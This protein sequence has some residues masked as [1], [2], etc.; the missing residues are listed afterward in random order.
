MDSINVYIVDDDKNKKP[1][2]IVVGIPGPSGDGGSGGIIISSNTG[3]GA[4]VAKS[5]VG[6]T[7]PFRTLVSRQS[8]ISIQEASN[9]NEVEID[10]IWARSEW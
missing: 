5:R 7:L 1:N 4:R 3:T 10:L 6:N 8:T 9:G 2:L